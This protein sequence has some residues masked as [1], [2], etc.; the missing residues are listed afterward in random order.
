MPVTSAGVLFGVFHLLGR[1][2][3]NVA[4]MRQGP[5]LLFLPIQS[6]HKGRGRVFYLS[7]WMESIAIRTRDWLISFI[8]LAELSERPIT[9]GMV[10]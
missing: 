10:E 7:R 2:G 8:S 3:G 1:A 5:F 4:G 9:M 6:R